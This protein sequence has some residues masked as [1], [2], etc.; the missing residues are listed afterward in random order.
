MS[1]I[2]LGDK[3]TKTTAVVNADEIPLLDS[4]DLSSGRKKVKKVTAANLK[5]SIGGVQSVVAG[6]NVTIDNTDPANPVISASG[7]GGGGGAKYKVVT[8]TAAQ[9][10]ADSF[11]TGIELLPAPGANKS[12]IL[13]RVNVSLPNGGTAFDASGVGRICL[14]DTSSF[15][16][17]SV[18]QNQINQTGK[19]P[20]QGYR[21]SYFPIQQTSVTDEQVASI[22]IN[23][24]LVFGFLPGQ[25]PTVGTNSIT[26][27]IYYSIADLEA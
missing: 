18:L 22:E 3:P 23:S 10:L 27:H 13:H 11:P 20:S 4:Q 2:Y 26:F 24:K 17:I 19:L 25:K 1:G 6:T 21:C 7:G 5:S 12:I 14:Q 15:A 8:I 9:V 16:F